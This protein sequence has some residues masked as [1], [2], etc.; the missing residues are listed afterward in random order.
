MISASPDLLHIYNPATT[1]DITAALPKTP[2]SL[3]VTP[4]G[5]HAAVGHDGLLTWIDLASASIIKTFPASGQVKNVV[6][7]DS[8]LWYFAAPNG[9]TGGPSALDLSSGAAIARAG[10]LYYATSAVFDAKQTALYLSQDGS[11]PNDMGKVTITSGQVGNPRLWPYHGDYPDCGPYYLS[12]DGSR[13]YTSC[14]TVV[15]GSSDP[16]FDMYYL[17]TLPLTSFPIAGLAESAGLKKVAAIPSAPQYSYPPN[18]NPDTQVQLFNTDYLTPARTISLLPFVIPSGSFPAHGRGCSSVKMTRSCLLWSRPIPLPIF[19]TASPWSSSISPIRYPARFSWA[20]RLSMSMAR[21]RLFSSH[22]PNA[23]L[24][25]Q[26]N[27]QRGLDCPRQWSV[28]F[29]KQH[30]P[31]DCP[32]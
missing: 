26:R 14:G 3:G 27:Q 15:H 24:F 6:L 23:R 22:H 12:A 19:P 16:K 25:L 28:R 29:R 10:S 32:A 21:D 13:I 30:G 11:S 17:R 1:S 2:L 8:Y 7:G 31:M 9:P 20:R 5:M 18:P 4:D